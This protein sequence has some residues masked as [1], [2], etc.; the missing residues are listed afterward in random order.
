MTP[1]RG[2]SP[3]DWNDLFAEPSRRAPR[4]T[5][6]APPP[7]PV[8]SASNDAPGETPAAAIS[9]AALNETTRLVVEG[10]FIPLWVRGEICDFRSHRNGHWYFGL[11]D[12]SAQVRCVVWNRDQHRFLAAPDDGMQVVA[13]GQPTV[14]AARGDLQFT[15]RAME[16]EGDGLRRKAFELALRRL[17]KDGLLDPARR[18]PIP[19]APARVA[20]ITSPSGAALH[21]VLAVVRR[22]APSVEVVVIPA[23]VQGPSAP[24]ELIRALDRLARW[25]GADVVIIGRG[26]GA[27]EDLAAFNDERVARAVAACTIPTISAVGHEVDVTLCDLVA[28]LRAPTPSAAAEHAVPDIRQLRAA[29]RAAGA[30][31]RAAL[32]RNV[33][34]RHRRAQALAARLRHASAIGIADRRTRVGRAGARLEALSPLATLARG[35]AVPRDASGRTLRSAADFPPGTPFALLVADGTV[36]ARAEGSGS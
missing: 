28:D 17:E 12:G 35:Y 34:R 22:R 1:R 29:L 25:G 36:H 26:G 32:V 3:G 21:D 33:D 9:V 19:H 18:R 31:M 2:S 30:S 11:R 20:V 10:A 5:R 6:S 27:N 8:P 4:E 16:A 13:L 7:A 24:A 23:T 15:V 14:Y